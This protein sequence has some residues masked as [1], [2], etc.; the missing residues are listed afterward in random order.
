MEIYTGNQRFIV[1]IGTERLSFAKVSNLESSIQY[2]TIQIGGINDF[3]YVTPSP[4]KQA[5]TILFERAIQQKNGILDKM[6]P[7][8]RLGKRLEIMIV[9]TDEKKRSK[10]DRK[11]YIT[12]GLVT[13]WEM[14]PLDALGNEVLIQKFEIAHTGL[15]QEL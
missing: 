12:D 14:T 2:D 11:Y 5:Q 8:I 9:K 6:R 15:Y 1:C 7:G 10:I 4:V 3:V 13:K